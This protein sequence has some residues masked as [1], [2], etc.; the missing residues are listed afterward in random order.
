MTLD[1]HSLEHATRFRVVVRG[2]HFR[3]TFDGVVQQTGFF[4]TLIVMARDSNA[5]EH[6][7]LERVRRNQ[8][9]IRM[10]VDPTDERSLLFVTSI[11]EMTDG[12]NDVTEVDILLVPESAE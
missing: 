7:A 6:V 10:M 12:V 11:E 9:L 1:P 3:L 2:R 8:D 4:A 5:A